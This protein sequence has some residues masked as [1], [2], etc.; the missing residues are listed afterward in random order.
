MAEHEHEWIEMTTLEDLFEG[1]PERVWY[2][3]TAGGCLEWRR[4][5]ADSAWIR[6][7]APDGRAILEMRRQ[8]EHLPMARRSRLTTWLERLIGA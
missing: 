5:P 4:E 6:Q 1:S 7:H 8:H 2:C 3:G